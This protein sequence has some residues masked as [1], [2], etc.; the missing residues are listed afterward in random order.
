MSEMGQAEWTKTGGLPV[1]GV[2]INRCHFT[3]SLFVPID[4]FPSPLLDRNTIRQ[5]RKALQVTTMKQPPLTHQ[6]R[7]SC[8]LVRVPIP[9]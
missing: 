2:Q 6:I 8:S 7:L 4:G 1:V 9:S 3:C 5:A